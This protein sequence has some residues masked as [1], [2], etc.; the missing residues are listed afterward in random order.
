M[1]PTAPERVLQL[2]NFKINRSYNTVN[3][4]T[5]DQKSNQINEMTRSGNQRAVTTQYRQGVKAV[6]IKASSQRLLIT[7]F[8]K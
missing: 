7:K 8:H 3:T 2:L 6:L 5:T 4:F 1:Y